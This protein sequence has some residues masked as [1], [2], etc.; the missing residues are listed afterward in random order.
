MKIISVTLML[1]LFSC[2][3][4]LEN[5]FQT[6]Q[7]HYINWS[8]DCANWATADDIKNYKDDALAERCV[9]IEPADTSLRLPDA[10]GYINDVVEFTGQFYIDKGFPSGHKSGERLDKAKVFRYSS[11]KIIKSNYYNSLVDVAD[12]TSY[13]IDKGILNKEKKTI[14]VSYTATACTCPQ[15]AETKNID[16]T[17]NIDKY[18]YLEPADSNLIDA[19]TLFDG[20]RFPVILSLYGQFYS[21]E[22]YPKNYFPAKGEPEP[23]RVFRYKKLKIIRLG[24][25]K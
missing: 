20:S 15:W 3:H 4:K 10:I 5:K 19:D 6:L 21:K 14:E 7:F 23:A 18:F 2:S 25:K 9:F 13:L 16:D 12:S 24:N 11:Y 1:F 17:N 8:C 22:G